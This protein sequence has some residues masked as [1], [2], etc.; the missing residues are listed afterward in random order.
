[1]DNCSLRTGEAFHLL[2]PPWPW[3]WVALT[4]YHG[5]HAVTFR[6]S[7]YLP[8]AH[9]HCNVQAPSGPLRSSRWTRDSWEFLQTI[10][11]KGKLGTCSLVFFDWLKALTQ[12]PET[13]LMELGREEESPVLWGWS[14]AG[15][16]AVPDPAL[17]SA[18]PS[19]VKASSINSHLF[20]PECPVP[21]RLHCL[22]WGSHTE[23][24]LKALP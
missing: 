17:L 19:Q 2:L 3:M 1:M 21:P 14:R 24:T 10:L 16:S 5:T 7:C 18:R 13:S 11:Y 4:V 20:A 9:R 8:N 12:A 15:V 6:R 22:N 23:D